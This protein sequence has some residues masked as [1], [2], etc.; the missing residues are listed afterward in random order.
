VLESGFTMC[1]ID[2]NDVLCKLIQFEH[3]N[4]AII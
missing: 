4:I 3:A 2:I 1:R